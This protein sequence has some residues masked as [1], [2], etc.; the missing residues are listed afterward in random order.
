MN[1]MFNRC[2]KL[3]SLNLSNFN[4]NNVLEMSYMF[5]NCSSLR[6]LD[7]NNFNCDNI[8]TTDKMNEMFKGCEEL[9]ID[10]VKYRDFKIRNQLLIDL[11]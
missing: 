3:T 7:I 6:S 8:K 1:F 9:K 10:H 2:A 11:E 4:T 5:Y